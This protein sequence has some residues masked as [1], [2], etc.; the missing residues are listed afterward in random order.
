MRCL[1]CLCRKVSISFKLLANSI[2]F[3]GGPDPSFDWRMICTDN[4]KA[5]CLNDRLI[6]D[7]TATSMEFHHTKGRATV[8]YFEMP[9]AQHQSHN[10]FKEDHMR[11]ILAAGSTAHGANCYHQRSQRLKNKKRA[12]R[13]SLLWK[14]ATPLYRR[15][16]ALWNQIIFWWLCGDS[17]LM[18]T[19]VRYTVA[20]HLLFLAPP[21]T[22]GCG[23]RQVHQGV[24]LVAPKVRVH[25]V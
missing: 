5:H 12:H 25:P 21:I 20:T 23:F 8:V 7:E 3:R 16:A 2:I 11:C 13:Q 14:A 10:E 19:C 6:V 1:L 24:Y 4:E 18:V 17:A 9:S 22:T 15:R